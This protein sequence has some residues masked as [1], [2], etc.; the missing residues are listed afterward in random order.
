MVSPLSQDASEHAGPRKARGA[1]VLL[2]SIALSLCS[3]TAF[4]L[5]GKWHWDLFF[6]IKKGEGTGFLSW[7]LVDGLK[8]AN[9]VL[10]IAA[11]VCAVVGAFSARK[12]LATCAVLLALVACGTVVIIT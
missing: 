9:V 4:F 8:I 12:G 10:A 6:A 3:L 2:V 7:A 5:Y 1:P 11:L